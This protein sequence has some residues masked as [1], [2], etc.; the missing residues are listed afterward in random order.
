[1]GRD[2]ERSF[3][4]RRSELDALHAALERAV[5]GRPRIVLLAGQPGIGKTRTA[6]ELVD[7]AGRSNV[8]ALWGRCPEEPGAPPYW[9]WRQLIRR[10]VALHD[11]PVLRQ[12]MGCAAAQ[13]AALDPE[14]ARGL[15]D[16]PAP[17]AETDA[18]ASR[19]RLFDSI[20]GF[21]QRAAARQ[22][23]LLVLDDLH[24]ADVP[25]LRLLEFVMA[26]AGGSALMLLGTYRD[27]EV[28]RSHPLSDTL[29][30]LHRHAH[31]QRLLLGGFTPAETA[32]FVAAA[33]LASTES[34]AAMHEQ[35]EGHPL[36]LA[37]LARD[38]LQAGVAVR[39]PGRAR[40]HRLSAEPPEPAVR[41]RSCACAGGPE[42]YTGKDMLSAH[43]HEH[44]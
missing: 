5:A 40:S 34:A 24:R 36:F 1:M 8:L 42:P 3:I 2:A 27:A 30:Q 25:S 31:V 4:G 28:T 15:T 44:Q 18:A 43:K 23:L 32:Q 41:E 19:F 10:Y 11:E 9:P 13:I 22:P 26:E 20:A 12:T 7:H 35:A 6:Q 16:G 33:G 14:L 37:E 17:P 29:A 39:R 21:W 38:M